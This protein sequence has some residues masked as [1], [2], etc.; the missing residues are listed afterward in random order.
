[1]DALTGLRILSGLFG[2]PVRA[3]EGAMMLSLFC[4]MPIRTNRLPF[5]FVES[6]R[7]SVRRAGSELL[8]PNSMLE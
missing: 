1:M 4:H 8:A 5:S 7:I 6:C 2:A 3:A